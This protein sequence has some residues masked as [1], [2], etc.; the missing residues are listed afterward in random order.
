M[1]ELKE[2]FLHSCEIFS[3]TVQYNNLKVCDALASWWAPHPIF[4]FVSEPTENFVP[5]WR[6]RK[7]YWPPFFAG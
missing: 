5:G 6:G 7:T 2:L 3:E 1:S 4:V